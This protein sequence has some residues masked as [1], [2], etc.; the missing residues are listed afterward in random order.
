MNQKVCLKCGKMVEVDPTKNK[1]FCENCG[2]LVYE[3]D[4]S[5][6]YLKVFRNNSYFYS[7]VSL[8]VYVDGVRQ[9][10]IANGNDAVIPLNFGTHDVYVKYSTSAKSKRYNI[11]LDKD[12]NSTSLYV[13]PGLFI[14]PKTKL[15][16]DFTSSEKTK[17]IL[18]YVLY[19]FAIFLIFFILGYF[20]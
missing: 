18:L 4:G 16:N 12:H 19:I 20:I 2:N 10:V 9:A 17:G 11:T 8:D 7:V 14:A 15:D 1:V 13:R 6:G 3:N 5:N